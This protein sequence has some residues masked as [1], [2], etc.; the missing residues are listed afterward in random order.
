MRIMV[1]IIF[2]TVFAVNLGMLRPLL[3]NKCVERRASTVLTK[4]SYVKC[5]NQ[6]RLRPYCL[7]VHYKRLFKVCEINDAT[8]VGGINECLRSVY[9]E[10]AAT[11]DT[12]FARITFV[13]SVLNVLKLAARYLSVNH[14]RLAQTESCRETETAWET[15]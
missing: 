11:D 14:F 6:C 12:K 4:L 2:T 1:C 10:K 3:F 15:K 5:L 8:A 13:H 9:K 7:S